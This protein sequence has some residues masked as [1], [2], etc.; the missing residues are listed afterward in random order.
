MFPESGSSGCLPFA[1]FHRSPIHSVRSRIKRQNSDNRFTTGQDGQHLSSRYHAISAEN[2]GNGG[3]EQL[4]DRHGAL[5]NASPVGRYR[6]KGG[7]S[8]CRSSLSAPKPEPDWQRRDTE[9]PPTLRVKIA[10]GWEL[11]FADALRAYLAPGAFPP[12]NH[13]CMSRTSGAKR[14]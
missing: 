12:A 7:C 4:G 5:W 1:L 14:S 13:G 9:V 2:G 3:I 11:L 6:A 8:K 10:S